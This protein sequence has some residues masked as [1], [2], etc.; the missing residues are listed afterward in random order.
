MFVSAERGV[1]CPLDVR[2]GSIYFY[3]QPV[4]MFRRDLQ[5]IGF[6]KSLDR[7]VIVSGRAEP[8]REL[9]RSEIVMIIRAARIVELLEKSAE[10][11]PDCATASQWPV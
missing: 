8:F 3:Q 2:D 9:F 4:A 10:A 7:F 1:Q 6:R 11:P 5:A